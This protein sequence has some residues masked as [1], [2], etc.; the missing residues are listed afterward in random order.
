M[1][2]P[3]VQVEDGFYHS[4]I[5]E[6]VTIL[7]FTTWVIVLVIVIVILRVITRAF[8]RVSISRCGLAM[9]IGCICNFYQFCF[10]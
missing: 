9:R 5:L 1:G 6:I 3:A 4:V 2:N 10:W 7:G 8:R